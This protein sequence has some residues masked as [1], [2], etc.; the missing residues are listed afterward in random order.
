MSFK[1]RIADQLV[2]TDDS[3]NR[4]R[5]WTSSKPYKFTKNKIHSKQT[6]MANI[7]S[8]NINDQSRYTLVV[9]EKDS[10]FYTDNSRY[11]AKFGNIE[12]VNLV[13]NLYQRWRL[14]FTHG[15]T[16]AQQDKKWVIRTLIITLLSLIPATYISYQKGYQDG[17]A[18]EVPKAKE[19]DS[20]PA[21][22]QPQ[23]GLQDTTLMR[24]SH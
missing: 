14:R 1:A 24:R 10:E 16:W 17:R 22:T 11:Q 19:K 5:T 13:T 15:L 3:G 23:Q 8:G 18:N 21:I 20:L 2:I 12:T 9:L 7:T 6:I 4:F